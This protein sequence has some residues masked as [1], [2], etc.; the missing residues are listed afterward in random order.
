MIPLTH[1]VLASNNRG[2]LIELERL[3]TDW[4]VTIQPQAVFGI[5]DVAEPHSSF[6]ENALSKAR[7]ACRISG[8]AALADDSGLCV[9]ALGGQPGVHSARYAGVPRLDEANN[10]K[11]LATLA[12]VTARQAYY[13]A[14]LVLMRHAEDPQ[15]LIADGRVDGEILEAPRGQGGFGYDPLFF[16][17]KLGKS[18]AELTLTEKA[19]ISHRGAALRELLAKLKGSL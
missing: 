7:H 15:P 11:L 8:L 5:K 1:V 19:A 10:A 18:V 13:Y 14:V 17:P 9:P 2:K 4:P 16:I 12:T 3:L 6:I